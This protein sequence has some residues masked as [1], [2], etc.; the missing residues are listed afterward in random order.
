MVN[1]IF[2]KNFYKWRSNLNEICRTK[3]L[4]IGF[5]KIKK[6]ERN[7]AFHDLSNIALSNGAQSNYDHYASLMIPKENE[8][9]QQTQSYQSGKVDF[10]G[11]LF[12]VLVVCFAT[13][14]DSLLRTAKFQH[15]KFSI[16]PI[17]WHNFHSYIISFFFAT[18]RHFFFL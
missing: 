18:F 11:F 15:K 10:R 14:Q 3:P 4:K 13:T 17:F 9:D 5:D 8:T 1:K 16:P 2:R 12:V 7:N 6:M